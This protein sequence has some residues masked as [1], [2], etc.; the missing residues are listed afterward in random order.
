M[1]AKRNFP[2]LPENY[3]SILDLQ[4]RW[5]KQQQQE[6]NLQKEEEHEAHLQQ[7]KLKQP[8]EQREKEPLQSSIETS[9]Q[10]NPRRRNRKALR[11]TSRAK[12]PEEQQP[13]EICVS[14]S[15]ADEIETRDRKMGDREP[16]MARK[17]REKKKKKKKKDWN[18]KK[19]ETAQSV[20]EKDIPSGISAQK[21][22]IGDREVEIA[23]RLATL[24]VDGDGICADE[25]RYKYNE[26]K[27]ERNG[28]RTNVMN[29]PEWKSI[30][31]RGGGRTSAM[32]R[33][34]WRRNGANVRFNHS[35]MGMERGQSQLVWVRKGETSESTGH[36]PSS[37]T[38]TAGQG[39]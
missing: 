15:I 14:V 34:D 3:V 21:M 31:E 16:K 28:G 33:P 6:Q 13:S 24:S 36:D 5:L 25:S 35:L 22:G 1:E 18:L 27:K 38:E 2:A 37:P 11:G 32:T 23:R 30:K 19:Q 12:E 20:P 4:D 10:S 7:Q 9:A 8:E 39:K 26:G 29:L 17:Q